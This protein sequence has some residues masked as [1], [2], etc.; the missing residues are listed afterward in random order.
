MNK[1][2]SNIHHSNQLIED[3]ALELNVTIRGVEGKI[4]NRKLDRI[5]LLADRHPDIFIN[6]LRTLMQE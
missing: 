3:K 5:R 6:R 4:S 2:E 1:K